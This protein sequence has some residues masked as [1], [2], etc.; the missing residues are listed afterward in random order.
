ML[1]DMFRLACAP[2]R[3]WQTDELGAILRHQLSAPV[4]F[5][6]QSMDRTLADRLSRV[7]ESHGLLLK[8]F[9]DLLFHPSPP[10]ELLELTKQF[11]KACRNHPDSPLPH[12]VAMVLYLASIVTAMLRCGRRI[13]NM[14]D[15]ALCDSLE[16]AIRKPWLDERLRS[17]LNQGLDHLKKQEGRP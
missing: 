16:W 2:A 10:L 7:C 9:A 5:D 4:Q 14:N 6:L 12:D 15:Q 11:A 8:S 17:L 13:T 3:V 1:A